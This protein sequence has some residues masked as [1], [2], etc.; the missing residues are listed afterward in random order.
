ME[1]IKDRGMGKDKRIRD[2]KGATE[3]REI[4]EMVKEIGLGNGRRMRR[5]KK[6]MESGK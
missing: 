2:G 4:L 1:K 3:K 5:V 6:E